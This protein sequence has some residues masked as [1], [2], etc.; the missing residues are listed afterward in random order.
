[1]KSETFSSIT[2]ELL[3]GS[4]VSTQIKGC[5]ARIL[6][7]ASLFVA[8][9]LWASSAKAAPVIQLMTPQSGPVGTL[10]VIV[11]SGFG[12]SQGTSTV[13]FNGTPVTWVSWSATSLEVQVPAGASSGNVVVTVSGKASNAD[14]FTVTQ[15]PVITGL[16]PT[17]GAVGA[18]IAISGSNFTAGGTQSPQVVFNPELYASPISSTDTSITVAVPAG[19]ATGDL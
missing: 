19:A 12:A 16:S 8:C 14:S 6:L 2:A 7:A 17:S 1:M 13:T 11:G 5:V 15:S 9:F 18:T 3:T 10:V 4:D